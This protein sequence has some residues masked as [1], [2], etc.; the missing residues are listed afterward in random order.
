MGVGALGRVAARDASLELGVIYCVLQHSV[1]LA[2]ERDVFER[3][4]SDW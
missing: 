1:A 2:S 4:Q 3:G